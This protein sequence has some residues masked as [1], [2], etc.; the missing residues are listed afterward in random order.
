VV[1]LKSELAGKLLKHGPAQARKEI[2]EVEHIARAALGEVGQT[3]RGC[4]SE[5]L[6][7]EIERAR[8]TLEAAGVKLECTAETPNLRAAGSSTK[9]AGSEAC[10]NAWSPLVD[11][12]RSIPFEGCNS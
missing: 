6:G 1:V 5:G 3:I 2:G 8:S 12:F 7:A 10:A 4:R 9:A 11:G